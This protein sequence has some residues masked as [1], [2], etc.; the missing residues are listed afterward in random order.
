MSRGAGKLQRWLWDVLLH[1][2]TPLTFAD[3]CIERRAIFG[4]GF[5]ALMS[6]LRPAQVRSLR[7]ALQRMVADGV[8]LAQGKGG[9]GDPHRYCPHPLLFA[10]HGTR[11]QYEA[12]AAKAER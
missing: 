8:V 5:Q 1:S 4:E 7:R 3:I 10:A 9:P 2:D 6:P 12:A 11:E